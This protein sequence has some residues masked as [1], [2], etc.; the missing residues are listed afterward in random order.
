VLNVVSRIL[1]IGRGP[2]TSS[3]LEKT[4]KVHYILQTLIKVVSAFHSGVFSCLL[5]WVVAMIKRGCGDTCKMQNRKRPDRVLRWF[6]LHHAEL[7]RPRSGFPT[8]GGG[9]NEVGPLTYS[10]PQATE[11]E[12]TVR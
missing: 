11:I 2:D 3:W 1:S 10:T 4:S 8:L 12:F 7:L 5:A 6:S 9:R